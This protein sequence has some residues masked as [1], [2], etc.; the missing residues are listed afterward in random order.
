MTEISFDISTKDLARLVKPVVP[1][2]HKD[3]MLPLL[4]SVQLAAAGEYLTAAATDR[5]RIGISRIKTEAAPPEGLSIRI[6]LD[7]LRRILLI[8]KSDAKMERTVTITVLDDRVKVE[9]AFGFGFID[10]SMSFPLVVGDYPP[11]AK[12]FSAAQ[13]SNPVVS[14]GLNA[15]HLSDFRHAIREGEPLV[16]RSA[17]A[18]KPVIVTAG[19][20]F[21][22][23]LMPVRTQPETAT[24]SFDS[25]T[26]VLASMKSDAKSATSDKAAA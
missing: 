16:V 17:S 26:G 19:D 24:A 11:L 4:N 18:N 12:L 21:I 13:L 2:A 10:A 23:A 14:V 8:F 22:G 20:H 9:Q 5:Y 6:G 1:L 3:G 7:E 25:W 15:S